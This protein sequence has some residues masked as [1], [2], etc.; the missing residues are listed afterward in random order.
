MQGGGAGLSKLDFFRF[1][2]FL[3]SSATDIV[4]VTLPSTAVETAIAWCTSHCAI[5]RGRCLN[6][7]IVLAAVHGLSGLFWAVSAVEPSLSCPLP[8]L[9][10]VPNE[11]PRFSGRKAAWSYQDWRFLLVVFF[12]GGVSVLVIYVGYSQ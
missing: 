3:N 9:V 6:I 7:S 10:P 11:Q 4:L 12:L 5:V 8:P 2:L 1:G